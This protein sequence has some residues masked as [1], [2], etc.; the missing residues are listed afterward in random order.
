MSVA[1]LLPVVIVTG[2][3]RDLLL[4]ADEVAAGEPAWGGLPDAFEELLD[5]VA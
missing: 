2:L 5:P 1:S 4:T 3:H